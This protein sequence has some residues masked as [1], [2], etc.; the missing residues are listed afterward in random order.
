MVENEVRNKMSLSNVATIMAPNLFLPP[1]IHGKNRGYPIKKNEVDLAKDTAGVV[2]ALIQHHVKLWT[3]PESLM[4]TLRMRYAS[5]T[6]TT[7]PLKRMI[8]CGCF[9][10]QGGSRKN[11]TEFIIT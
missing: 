8:F 7:L 1:R 4:D 11:L 9:S 10:R 3:V 5:R 6:E 2:E